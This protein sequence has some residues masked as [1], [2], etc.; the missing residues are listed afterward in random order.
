MA[1]QVLFIQGGGEGGYAADGKMLASLEQSL[2]RDYAVSYPRMQTDEAAPDFGWLR[3][4]GNEIGRCDNDAILVAHSL[5]ASLLL[6]FLSEN[7]VSKSIGGIF[8]LSTPFWSGNEKWVQG[9]ILRENFADSLPRDC[10]IFFYHCRDDKEIPSEQ[11]SLYKRKV[12]AATFRV[13]DSGGHQFEGKIDWVA[14]DIKRA[15]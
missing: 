11:L 5:G 3:Q 9:L 4:I 15:I 2:G 7:N 1:K 14:K 6:K 12:P 8:L 10:P 13:I